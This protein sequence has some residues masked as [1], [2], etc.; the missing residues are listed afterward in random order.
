MYKP[1]DAKG[2]AQ[3]VPVPVKPALADKNSKEGVEA[4]AKYWYALLNYALETGNLKPVRGITGPS[5]ALCSK[6]FPGI[7]KWNKDGKWIVGAGI[8]VRAVQSAFVRT[9][10]GEYQVAMQSQQSAG[11]L[12][13]AD[14]TVGQTVTESPMLGDLMIAKYVDGRW[15]ANNVDRLGG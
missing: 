9:S 10:S 13:Q 5:C 3:N 12:R 2:K 7:E 14:G 4:F 6:I 1:A 15:K 11:S 8:Q